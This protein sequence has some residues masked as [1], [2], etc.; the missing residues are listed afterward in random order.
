[1]KSV[2]DVLNHREQTE[3]H[4]IAPIETV[5][6][7]IK[8]MSELHVGLLPVLQ[9]NKLVG[10]ISERDYARKVILKD[11]ASKTT[12]VSEIMTRDVVTVTKN[13][14]VD[15]CVALMKK[16]RI[17]HL[18]VMEEGVVEGVIS[19]RDLFSEIIDEQSEQISDLVHYIRG[20][21]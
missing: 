4:S 11:K 2:L 13:E 21:T 3:L 12:R 10:V 1:M 19:I 5:F 17:R 8:L 7:A 16:H 14:R 9:E 18:I 20:E 15:V 6:E